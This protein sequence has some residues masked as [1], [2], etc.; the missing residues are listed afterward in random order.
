[1]VR[2]NTSKIQQVF[3]AMADCVTLNVN[4]N[5]VLEHTS[6]GDLRFNTSGGFNGV[7]TDLSY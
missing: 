1:M 5:G 6:E 3:E 4:V 7:N 2:L